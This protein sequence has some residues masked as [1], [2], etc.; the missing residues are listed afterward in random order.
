[1][2]FFICPVCK[3]KLCIQNKSLV[4]SNNHT[5]D[6]AKSGYVNLLLSKQAGKNVHGDNKLTVRARRDFLSK[7]YYSRL[8]TVALYGDRHLVEMVIHIQFLIVQKEFIR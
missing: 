6:I 7:G 3:E 2:D 5:F 1:M 4:C 8:L